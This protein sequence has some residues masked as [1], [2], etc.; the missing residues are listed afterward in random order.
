MPEPTFTEGQRVYHADLG[1]YA[2]WLGYEPS[3]HGAELGDPE[4]YSKVEMED[5]NGRILHCPT[6]ALRVAEEDE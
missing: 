3:Y 5:T 4:G 2:R 1:S 6:S